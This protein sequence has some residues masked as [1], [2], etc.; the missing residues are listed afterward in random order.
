MAADYLVPTEVDNMY[1]MP[2]GPL[3]P[4]PAEL[5]GSQRMTELIEELKAQADMVLF[6]SPPLLGVVDAALLAHA[7]DATLLVI[8]AGSTRRDALTRAKEQLT[9][10]GAR[11]LGVVLNRVSTPRRSYYDD[12]YSQSKRHKPHV[13]RRGFGLPFRHSRNGS[14]PD[15]SEEVDIDIHERTSPGRRQNGNRRTE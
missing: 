5:L 11:L 1:L 2:S 3:P 4:N 7:C 12:Y 10:S 15:S 6:D 9:Q 13:R 8:L 14:D